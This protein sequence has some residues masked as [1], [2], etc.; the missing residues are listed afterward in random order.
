MIQLEG[1]VLEQDTIVMIQDQNINQDIGVVFNGEQE[2][3]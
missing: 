3:R 1:K 2:L